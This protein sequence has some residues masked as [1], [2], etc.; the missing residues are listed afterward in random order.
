MSIGIAPAATASGSCVKS[1]VL[2]V[3]SVAACAAAT[4]SWRAWLLPT[5]RRFIVP[6]LNDQRLSIA[7]ATSMIRAMIKVAPR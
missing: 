6:A 4:T 7:S 5:T 1:G 3:S 2:S